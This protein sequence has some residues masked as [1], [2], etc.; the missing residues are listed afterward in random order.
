M[1]RFNL[2]QKEDGF[3]GPT[4]SLGNRMKRAI[5][6]MAWLCLARWTPPFAHRFR[7][8]VLKAFGAQVSWKAYV[9]SNVEIW[10]PWHLVIEDYGTL[11]RNVIC[12][13]IAP[14]VLRKRAVVSQGVH[15]CSGSHDFLDPEFPLTAKPIIIGRRAWVCADAFVGPGVSIGDGAILAAAGVVHQHLLPWSIYS[16]NPAKFLRA[17]PEIND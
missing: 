7:I 16:G 15:L 9:Y 6:I 10:A 2:L 13:N 14:V 3:V 11:G 17:R 5:W 4:F 1:S 12:Y 8:A